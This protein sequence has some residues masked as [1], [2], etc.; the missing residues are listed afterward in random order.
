MPKFEVG[1][2]CKIL[3][4]LLENKIILVKNQLCDFYLWHKLHAESIIWIIV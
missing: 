3:G 4:L 2:L 1:Y